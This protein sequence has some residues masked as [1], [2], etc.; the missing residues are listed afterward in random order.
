MSIG[1]FAVVIA[2]NE[3]HEEH[4]SVSSFAGLGRRRPYLAAAFTILLF[5]LA[6][7]PPT[8]GFVARY[9]IFTSSLEAGLWWLALVGAVAGVVAAYAYLRVIVIMYM[10]RKS[11]SKAL[12][13]SPVGSSSACS[14]LYSS[15]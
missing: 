7:L 5:A 3:G 10:H 9:Y 11:P 1:A 15:A 14:Q 2:L 13:A 6:G 4:H 12:K 8:L